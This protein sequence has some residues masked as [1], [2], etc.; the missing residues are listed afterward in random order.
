[1]SD[2]NV[3]AGLKIKYLSADPSNPESG[4]VW[5]NSATSKL[6]AGGILGVGSWSSGGTMGTARRILGRAGTVPAG[7]AVGGIGPSG[8]TSN[9]TEEYNGSAWTGGGNMS[10]GLYGF[11]SDGSQTAS[12]AAAG[13]DGAQSG[14]QEYDGSSWTAGNSINS[15][16]RYP[17][18]TGTQT[19]G[20]IFGGVSSSATET[21]NG[22]TWSSVGSMNTA[23][24]EF[25]GAG[26]QTAT[27][28]FGGYP[29]TASED[30]NG[31]AWTN[32]NNLSYSV[33]ANAGAGIQTAAISIG[34]GPGLAT[35]AV[36]DGT[37]WS[38]N[39]SLATGRS[40]AG[41]AGSSSSDSM[42]FGGNQ[43]GITGVTE[44][45]LVP[46]GTANISSS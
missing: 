43:P 33:P 5:Y 35:T 20:L 1:M 24:A 11:A 9:L 31:S 41:G 37:N 40:S 4:Q 6:R 45:F 18:G 26:T 7:L 30:W 36:Y 10:T 28:G 38:S 17:V 12:Y 25:A 44:E 27:V 42:I 46:V 3:I 34:G 22:S 13:A 23:R 16:R 8:S 21:Y 39:P 2:Y 14:S 32:G 15:G 19:A 29:G